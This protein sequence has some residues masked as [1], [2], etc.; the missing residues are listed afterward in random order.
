MTTEFLPADRPMTASVLRALPAGLLLLLL[1]P[2]LPPAGWRLK[3]AV[4]GALNIGAFF[5]LLF[6][7]A[8]RLP[9]GL[10]AVVGS[11]QPLVILGLCLVLGWGRPRTA[12]VLWSF[13]ALAGVSLVALTG[14]STV[15]AI[16]LAAAAAG[17][18]SMAI[19]LLLTRR[20][21]VAP[22]MHPLTSTAWQLIVGG[23]LIVPLIPLVDHGAWQLDAPAVLGYAWL[24]VIGGALAYALWFRGARALPSANMALLGV[25]S[26]LTAA[27]LGLLALDQSLSPLQ[28]LG[29]ALA[30]LGSMLGQIKRTPV[31]PN[32]V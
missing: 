5:P 31:H 7:A 27:V 8:Y 15:D 17:A 6:L 1:A 13:V 30:L 18:F 10:A 16:G 32:H 28:C 25:L 14:Q 29:F 26:P 24:S 22:G 23:T 2:G 20:W 11:I 9:G 21:G 3:T 12:Q 19:G 4:L